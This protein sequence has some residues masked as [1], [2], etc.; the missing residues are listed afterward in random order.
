MPSGFTGNSVCSAQAPAPSLTQSND[1]GASGDALQN[2]AQDAIG[3][4]QEFTCD[5]NVTVV[6]NKS[7]CPSASPTPDKNAQADNNLV[8]LALIIVGGLV[9]FKF[10]FEK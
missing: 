7:D 2:Q 3:S 6:L 4:K 10:A 8:V 5:D 1:G 9:V